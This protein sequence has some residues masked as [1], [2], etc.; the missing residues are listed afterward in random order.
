M[1][2]IISCAA[3]AMPGVAT[4]GHPYNSDHENGKIQEQP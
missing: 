1:Y 3:V 4:E 2:G